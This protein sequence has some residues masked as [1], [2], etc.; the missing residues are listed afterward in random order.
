MF[1]RGKGGSPTSINMVHSVRVMNVHP[2][3]EK[4]WMKDF[5]ATLTPKLK[6]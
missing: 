2:E 6:V 3:L 5:Q 4:I 1:M